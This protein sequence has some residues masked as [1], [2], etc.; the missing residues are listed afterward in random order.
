MY[1]IIIK[2]GLVFDGLDN[3]PEKINIGVKD[4]RIHL[5]SF[6]EQAKEEISAEERY[7]SPG[8]ID[9]DNTADHYLQIF[10][11]SSADN[12]I[13][14]GVTTAI[15]GN[16]GV[17]LAP[18]ISG[19]LRSIRRWTDPSKTNI[20]WHTLGELFTLLERNGIG[21][22]F[23]TLLGWGTLREELAGEEFRNLTT[24]E[25]SKLK[26]LVEQG[27][28]DG[29]MG[30]SFGLGYAPEKVV[31]YTE[32]LAMADLVNKYN[33]YLSFHLRDEGEKFLSSV[34]EITELAQRGKISVEISHFKV[35]APPHFKDFPRA[36]K[37]ITQTNQRKELVN[38]DIYPYSS[39]E[40]M[41]SLIVPQW[42]MI[43]G[44][45]VFLKNIQQK[46]EKKA[47]I[48]ELKRRRYLY[49]GLVVANAG[50]EWWLRGKTLKEIAQGFNL[51]LEET[52]LR[53][54]QDNEDSVTVFNNNIDPGNLEM[55]ICSP[56]SFIASNAGFY[57]LSDP[58]K[59]ELIHPRAFGT[60][61]HFLGTYVREKK[62]LSWKEAIYKITGKVAKKIGL[63]KRG[64]IKDNY[65]ADIVVFNPN[66]IGSS[67]N[68]TDPFQ[69]PKGIEVVI[70]NG[71]LVYYKGRVEKG[72]YGKILKH[73]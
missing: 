16:C 38:F 36:L 23:G 12:L 39:N 22:N 63:S 60:F 5:L 29:A 51:S 53:L 35:V 32:A 64:A 43:G 4:G 73:P 20:D 2:N 59:R 47:V 28:K 34:D 6:S 8:F 50:K 66:L 31:G 45:K 72:K 1:D 71:K 69:Y 48:Q 33:G 67:A 25:L 3:E 41:L 10:S 30:V 27:L 65:L 15:G 13:R 14:Q 44:R 19:S 54:L 52:I 24:E 55:G 18:L 21:V 70:I 62:V 42:V 46:E 57:S 68:L 17:S 7:V 26:F 49:Q 56:Y 61:P 9:I 37:L 11:S 58:I 40:Q